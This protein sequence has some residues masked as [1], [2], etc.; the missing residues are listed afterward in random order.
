M[1]HN[2]RSRTELALFFIILQYVQELVV[3]EDDLTMA[4]W[5]MA[6]CENYLTVPQQ[7]IKRIVGQMI[8]D[9]DQPMKRS[10]EMIAE[11]TSQAIMDIANKVS[12]LLMKSLTKRLPPHP[13]SLKP[14]VIPPRRYFLLWERCPP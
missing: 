2:Q 11:L 7:S 10:V 1:Y 13:L 9:F 12:T 3:P 8:E 6:A 4:M 5:N 14:S